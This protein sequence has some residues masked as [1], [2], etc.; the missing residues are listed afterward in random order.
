[1]IDPMIE[2]DKTI[3]HSGYL[4]IEKL[5]LDFNEIVIFLFTTKIY[6][7]NFYPLLML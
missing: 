3:Q 5:P 1:M 4:A 2:F 6:H 7:F